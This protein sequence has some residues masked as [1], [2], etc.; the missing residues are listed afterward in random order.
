MCI[1]T[2]TLG[3]IGM[4]QVKKNEPLHSQ[5]Y[6]IIKK[7]IIE[8]ELEPGE[9]LVEVKLA[10]RLGTSRGPVRE[11]FRMLIQDGLLVQ[12]EVALFIFNPD[13]KDI[14]DVFQ[15]RQGLE[16]LTA[17][18]S[19]GNI[20]DEQ[21]KQLELNLQ[22]TREAVKCGNIGKISELDQQFHDI[23]ALS[24]KNQ[25]LIQL[26][27]VLKSKVIF[28]RTCIIR[29]YYRNFLYFVDDHQLIY[30]ALQERSQIKAEKEMKSHIQKN[31]EVSYTLMNKV[32]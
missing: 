29:N 3:E 30:E 27:E 24:S 32:E 2:F 28:I 21:L 23:I 5:I 16:S 17:K 31:L 8:G 19:A 13:T 20:T 18:L 26:Y 4:L 22:E 10:E 15:C 6:Q 7:L 12:K 9:R 11:A 1:V 25:Q 14:T